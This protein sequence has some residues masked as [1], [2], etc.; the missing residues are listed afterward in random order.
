[1]YH[2]NKQIGFARVTTDYATIAYV[3]D[4][5]VAEAYRGQGLAQWLGEC[6]VAQ[7]ELQGLRRWI[8]TRR[9]PAVQQNR[10]RAA[11]DARALDGARRAVGV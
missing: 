7:P 9:A 10:L 4:V 6:V 5:F 1:M 3:G 8:L 11:R 2:G